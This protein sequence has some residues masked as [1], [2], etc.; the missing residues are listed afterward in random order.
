M[1]ENQGQNQG[2]GHA[3][4]HFTNTSVAN[5]IQHYTR[6]LLEYMTTRP[7]QHTA[8]E[9]SIATGIPPKTVY[10]ILG[11]LHNRNLINRPSK[12]IYEAGGTVQ[13]PPIQDENELLVHNFLAVRDGGGG[14][15]PPSNTSNTRDAQLPTPQQPDPDKD[16]IQAPEGTARYETFIQ[17]Q[18]WAVKVRQGPPE[19]ILIS[20][21]EAPLTLPVLARLLDAVGNRYSFDLDTACWHVKRIE[22]NRDFPTL[23]LEGMTAL[24]LRDATGELYRMYNKPSIG[25]RVE[26]AATPTGVLT[27]RDALDFLNGGGRYHDLER[28]IADMERK[29]IAHR[30]DKAGTTVEACAGILRGLLKEKG[31]LP[32][33]RIP[34]IIARVTGLTLRTAGDKWKV[35]KL[36]PRG[37]GFKLD[38]GS[39]ILSGG[40]P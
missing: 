40:Q 17:G 33:N 35:I 11:R 21:S 38:N 13:I 2:Q 37:Y 31:K 7:G 25:L 24:T 14:W 5:V 20:A 22:L 15:G 1:A 26:V 34:E 27:L 6:T 8:K 3:V 9:I 16:P 30:P 4:Q 36:S 12:G 32:W 28:R 29:N 39:L 18:G 23:K 10:T 19:E